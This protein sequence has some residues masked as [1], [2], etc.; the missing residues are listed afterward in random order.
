M[1]PGIHVLKRQS[2]PFVGV[3][4]GLLR[5][6]GESLCTTLLRGIAGK[7][8]MLGILVAKEAPLRLA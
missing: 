8:Q 3:G 7:D 1:E 2:S 5:G 6:R 4:S